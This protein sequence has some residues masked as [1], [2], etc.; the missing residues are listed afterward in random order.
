MP[1]KSQSKQSVTSESVK[2]AK[3]KRIEAITQSNQSR[4]QAQAH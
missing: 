3:R 2:A 1:Q 4:S